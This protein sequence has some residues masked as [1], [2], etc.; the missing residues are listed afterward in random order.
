MKNHGEDFAEAQMPSIVRRGLCRLCI[1]IV[2]GLEPHVTIYSGH[3]GFVGSEWELQ[4]DQDLCWPIEGL[5]K[6][7]LS[8]SM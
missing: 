3:V 5:S 1:V 4:G 6:A 7:C 8:L 2:L